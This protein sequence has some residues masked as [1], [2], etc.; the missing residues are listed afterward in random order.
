MW[1]PGL[2]LWKG[3]S[4]AYPL[5]CTEKRCIG[6]CKSMFS[7]DL[8]GEGKCYI[9]LILLT[10]QDLTQDC[11]LR[12]EEL[13][14]TWITGDNDQFGSWSWTPSRT[15]AGCGRQSETRWE[16][17]LVNVLLLA[18]QPVLCWLASIYVVILE[19]G[20]S[21]VLSARRCWL[22]LVT[23][24]WVLVLLPNQFLQNHDF[25]GGSPGCQNNPNYSQ[26]FG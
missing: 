16:W 24:K 9:Y 2:R 6:N 22:R 15:F 25:C 18:S 1:R 14:G 10:F 21:T 7:M 20:I 26:R 3:F 19:R 17:R 13:A 4:L 23:E 8:Y 12:K 11:L 5:G